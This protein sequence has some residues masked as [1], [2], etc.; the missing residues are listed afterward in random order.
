[1]KIRRI[2]PIAG[3]DG[4]VTIPGSK[5]Y[6][7]RALVIGG[8]ARGE[9]VLK[10]PLHAEDIEYMIRGLEALGIE[11]AR[12]PEGLVIQGANGRLS[13]HRQRIYLGGAG[14][15]VRFLTTVAGLSE[16]GV[17]ID[18]NDRMQERPIQDLLD[19]LRPLGVVARS[20]HGN[21]CPP[22]AVE[23]G[24]FQGGHTKIHGNRSSQFL[25]S[26]LICGPYAQ[27][28]VEVEVAGEL[29]SSSYVDLTLKVMKD[30]GGEASQRDD[31]IFT[32]KTGSYSGRE[33]FIEGDMSSAAY[34]FAA[35]AVTGGRVLVKGVNPST[36]QGD[37]GFLDL[38]EAMGCEVHRFG[39]TVEVVGDS[40]RAVDAD[41]K[42]MPD[43]VQ[44][45]AVVAAFGRGKTRISGIDHLRYKETDR[46]SALIREL[47]RM[48]VQTA[49]D[50][51]CLVIEGGNPQGAEIRTYNDHRMA[52]AFAV[53]GLRVPGV[54]I[55]DPDC[56]GKSLPAFWSLLEGLG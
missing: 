52:M 38:L 21:G 1:L 26:I 12:V 28:P 44:T 29:V 32:V 41:M 35:A 9:T 51:S 5:S 46:L 23:G 8:L 11:I 55:Q 14:T 37:G 49:R 15:A 20:V 7:A 10:N 6:T 56:V 45:L 3:L 39:D 27:G 30:F 2:R 25:S 22:V 31:R 18:G 4:E 24:S 19:A 40:L 34:F 50:G 48:G 36:R 42:T 33:Y 53:A 43:T 47:R 16:E 54:V 17:I 13:T